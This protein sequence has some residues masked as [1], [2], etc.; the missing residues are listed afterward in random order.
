MKHQRNEQSTA[1]AWIAAYVLIMMLADAASESLGVTKCVTAP[2]SLLLSAVLYMQIRRG[3]HQAYYGLGR[4]SGAKGKTV[5]FYLPLL[6][7]ATSNLWNG[8]TVRLGALETALYVISMCSVGFLEEL[9]FRGL[10][11]RALSKNGLKQAIVISSLTFGI[12]HLF[13]LL[14]GAEGFS[15]LLQICYA[16]AVG[17]L[18]T[19]IFLKSGSLLP[20][21]LTHA[22]INATN[23]FAVPGGMANQMIHSAILIAVSLLYAFFLLRKQEGAAAGAMRATLPDGRN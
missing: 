21:I 9:I 1:I 3:G 12:G 20:C 2:A 14:A 15:T 16:T 5:L 13:N 19:L 4:G 22:A 23:A 10:L 11:F 8:V 6:V 18:F 7:L 17:F